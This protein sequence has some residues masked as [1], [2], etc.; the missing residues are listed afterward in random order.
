MMG[1]ADGA[2]AINRR[3][4]FWV[5]ALIEGG[6]L[7][8]CGTRPTEEEVSAFFALRGYREWQDVTPTEERKLAGASS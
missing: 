4:V 1:C 8:L 6:V 7:R 2:Y 3:G 5:M